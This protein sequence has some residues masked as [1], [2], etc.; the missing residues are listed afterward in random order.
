MCII[1]HLNPIVFLNFDGWTLVLSKK[2]TIF[3]YSILSRYIYYYNNRRS[4][5]FF[6]FFLEVYIFPLVSLL[7]VVLNYPLSQPSVFLDSH[8]YFFDVALIIFS[9]ALFPTRSLA[10]SAVILDRPHW[11]SLKGIGCQLF[12]GAK[13]LLSI[14][15]AQTLA[16]FLKRIKTRSFWHKTDL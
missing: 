9:A 5:I 2:F 4:S 1:I 11:G 12:C 14:L 15:T 8:E 16:Y 13:K 3:W 7:V 6:L 10:I